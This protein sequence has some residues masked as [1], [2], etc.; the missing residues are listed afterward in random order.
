MLQNVQLHNLKTVFKNFDYWVNGEFFTVYFS[1]PE[2]QEKSFKRVFLNILEKNA[3][4]DFEL[5]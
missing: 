3:I 4:V 5:F 1:W 2:E